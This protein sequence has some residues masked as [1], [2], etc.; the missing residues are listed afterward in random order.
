MKSK[1]A[2]EAV[3]HM[4]P[5]MNIS[6]YIEGVL[7]ETEHIYNDTFFEQLDGIV[8]ALDNVKARKI[9]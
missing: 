8:N 2:A 9:Q 4:N 7:P 6:A 3:K 5:H 1:V